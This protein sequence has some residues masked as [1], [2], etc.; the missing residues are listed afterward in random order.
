MNM[1]A[2]LIS[3]AQDDSSIEVLKLGTALPVKQIHDRRTWD[4]H[5]RFEMIAKSPRV[6]LE[7]Y[8]AMSALQQRESDALRR[9]Y[10]GK[11]APVF[12]GR[13]SRVYDEMFRIATSN[14]D[15][16]SGVRIGAVLTGPP[17]V[18]KTTTIVWFGRRYERRRRAIHR[19]QFG[20]DEF[21]QGDPEWL[22]TPVIYVSLDGT[23]TFKA[24][25]LNIA[26]FLNIPKYDKLDELGL[27]SQIATYANNCG[28]SL[29][30]IDD[31][32]YLRTQF[33]GAEPLINDLKKWMGTIPATFIFAGNDC[34]QIGF[35]REWAKS[36]PS[37]ASQTNHRFGK[38][39][40]QPFAIDHSQSRELNTKELGDVLQTYDDLCVLLNHQS[41]D[42]AKLLMY[43]IDRTSGY[44]GAI[45][46]L[47]KHG[48][49]LAIANRTER[50]SEAL[51]NQ[52]SLDNASE[53]ARPD[54]KA[55][56]VN[57]TKQS[58]TP[59]DRKRK[60]AQ[61]TSQDGEPPAR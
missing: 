2:C 15:L 39:E 1:P 18:G 21:V 35:F 27:K 37:T 16:S 32:H 33:V 40:L 42:L 47:I 17:T 9:Q 23:R 44:M 54:R 52:I 48:A 24:L 50:Y 49:T 11:L 61:T 5:V 28:V 19:A 51:L 46:T 60:T 29:I 59:K 31:I 14:I 7:E 57:K 45:V 26:A 56:S 38:I 43:I 12:S 22:F 41:G 20:T 36:K 55:V 3:D 53:T 13:Y 4:E 30:L 25:L 10:T 6:T 58:R 8:N 34:E